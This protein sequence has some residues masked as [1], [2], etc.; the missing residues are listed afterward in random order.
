MP[1]LL[2][3]YEFPDRDQYFI[4]CNLVYH[5]INSLVSQ[6]C[7]ILAQSPSVEEF[8]MTN[9]MLAAHVRDHFAQF[10]LL[11]M[12]LRHP[13][14][15]MQDC[16]YHQLTPETRKQLIHM[17]YSLDESFLR[18]LVGRR[19]SNK[20]RREIA[21]IAEKCELQLRSCKRQFD[22]LSCVARRTEDLPGRLID[23]IKNCFLLPERLAECYAAVIFITSNR[24]VSFLLQMN[25]GFNRIPPAA[26]WVGRFVIRS[27]TELQARIILTNLEPNFKPISKAIINLA[28]GLSHA[29]EMRDFFLDIN[30]KVT[31]ISQHMDTFVYVINRTTEHLNPLNIFCKDSM[32]Q[33]GFTYN[34]F[35]TTLP[36]FGKQKWYSVENLLNT[37]ILENLKSI[38]FNNCFNKTII[39]FDDCWNHIRQQFIEYLIPIEYI[40]DRKI[41]QTYEKQ[42]TVMVTDNDVYLK[43]LDALCLTACYSRYKE[44]LQPTT[45]YYILCPYPCIVQKDCSFYDCKDHGIFSHEYECPCSGLNK[46]DT[47]SIECLTNDL[48]EIRQSKEYVSLAFD[49][50]YTTCECIY[51]SED[52]VYCEVFSLMV[53]PMP[54]QIF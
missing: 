11:E 16:A 25:T 36:L 10:T 21:D 3:R 44:N 29:R 38:H 37:K 17:Y 8:R 9:D 1:F 43:Y 19:L 28:C 23:N 13:D 54:Q 7:S 40:E 47:E 5:S 27:L 52:K 24:Y 2:S 53:L 45:D 12:G 33:N 22:N 51:T 18:E 48:Y 34:M 26:V 41:I 14:S 30:E 4:I 46:W 20:S 49:F 31:Y 35:N 6:A 32:L 39:I 15:F 42:K 50:L